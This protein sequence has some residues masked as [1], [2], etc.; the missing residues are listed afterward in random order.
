[1]SSTLSEY[2]P[3]RDLTT[4]VQHLILGECASLKKYSF[5]DIKTKVTWRFAPVSSQKMYPF[6]TLELKN[7]VTQ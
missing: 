6:L 7:K 3:F 4:H 2:R 5:L 1:M